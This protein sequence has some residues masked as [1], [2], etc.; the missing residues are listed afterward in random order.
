M[1]NEGQ[2]ERDKLAQIAEASGFDY[3]LTQIRF[4]A[5]YGAGCLQVR[6]DPG[7]K[8]STVYEN[9]VIKN[10]HGGVVLVGESFDLAVDH[11]ATDRLRAERRGG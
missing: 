1:R 4:T 11:D 9:K 8:V 2:G 3:A 10:H 7:N 5:G 6:I